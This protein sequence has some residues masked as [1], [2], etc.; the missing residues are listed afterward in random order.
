MFADRIKSERRKLGLTQEQLAKK[1][2]TS[3]QNITN[4]ETGYNIPSVD[5][6][7]K[8]SDFFNCSTDYLLGR[9]NCR[10]IN[11]QIQNYFNSNEYKNHQK[12]IENINDDL[13]DE[14]KL[15]E[16]YMFTEEQV[17]SNVELPKDNIE[18]LFDKLQD[19]QLLNNNKELDD[20]QLNVILNF[21]ENNKDMLKTLIN[22]EQNKQ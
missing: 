12:I 9:T 8:L 7:N 1:L 2:E 22:N 19:L 10:N 14:L 16:F 15:N 17:N 20:K 4:W 6:V 3:R 11:E 5:L 13:S 21:I 18:I